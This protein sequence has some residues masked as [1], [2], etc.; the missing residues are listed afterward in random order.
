MSPD[1]S[2]ATLAHWEGEPVRVLEALWGIPRFEA[3]EVLD[4]TNDRL[5]ALARG[6]ALPFTA[7]VA[8]R[9]RA[10]RGRSGRRWA[11]PAG[12]GLWMSVLLPAGDGESRLLIPLLVGLAA[13]RALEST[14]TGVRP[15]VKWPNDLLL[16]DRKVCGILCESTA[17]GV[18]AGIGVNVD[19]EPSDF[20][21]GL[22]AT[23]VSL[24]RA[25]GTRV[26]RRRLAGALL[27]E[28]RT[29]FARP[30][31]RLSGALAGEFRARD[32]LV[33]RRVRVEPGPSGRA[34]GVDAAGA[35]LVEDDDGRTHRV[36]AGTV[37]I[38][39]G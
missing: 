16:E 4:S 28:L 6:G 39:D 27:G 30:V 2:A 9:Q 10:G 19:Q 36:H 33:G 18:V 22:A 26:S 13:S 17:G 25:S 7:V 29:M 1:V 14:A 8:E 21:A 35:L 31:R 37:R 3:W 23:A 38:M 12:M 11:S 32:A 15:R 24:R 5:A 34:R 20:P